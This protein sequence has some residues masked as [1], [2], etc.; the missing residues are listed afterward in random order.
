MANENKQRCPMS[1]ATREMPI[2]ATASHHF[3]PQD[4]S[5]RKY[6]Q[7]SVRT[8]RN[9]D[10]QTA[11]RELSRAATLKNTGAVLRKWGIGL[12]HNTAIQLLGVTRWKRKTHV[13]TQTHMQS[14]TGNHPKVIGDWQTRGAIRPRSRI[15]SSHKKD[16]WSTMQHGWTSE[17]ALCA[18]QT[19]DCVVHNSISTKRPENA[20]LYTESGSVAAS[21]WGWEQ[22]LTANNYTG[23]SWG[24]GNVLELNYGHGCTTLKIYHQSKNCT[25]TMDRFHHPWIKA[26]SSC[27]KKKKMVVFPIHQ[28]GKNSEPHPVWYI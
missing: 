14:Q 16:K 2:K 20:G 5:D 28:A 13:H 17:T 9:W 4:G 23:T 22:G 27:L 7:V 25:L 3:T 8:W 1:L 19:Q 6:R 10:P 15:L 26:Q 24:D 11:L 21:A 12:S 18:R